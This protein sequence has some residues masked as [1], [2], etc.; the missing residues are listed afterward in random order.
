MRR[1]LGVVPSP[2]TLERTG[3]LNARQ[4]AARERISYC[5]VNAWRRA[6]HRGPD[7]CEDSVAFWTLAARIGL[8]HPLLKARSAEDMAARC[9]DRLLHELY[10]NR[11]Q[12]FLDQLLAREQM[13][14]PEAHQTW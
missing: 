8:R 1:E 3:H 14:G 7:A 11:A 9:D 12:K 10:A 13:L 6:V 5:Q 4:N 2:G